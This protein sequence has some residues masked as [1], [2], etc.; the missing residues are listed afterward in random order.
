MCDGHILLVQG[1]ATLLMGAA[2]KSQ[3]S[4]TLSSADRSLPLPIAPSAQ[5]LESRSLLPLAQTFC[6]DHVLYVKFFPVLFA[7]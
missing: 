2:A 7:C 5:V 3:S 4:A 6:A 1:D